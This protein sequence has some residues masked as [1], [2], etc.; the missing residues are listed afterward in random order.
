MVFIWN[1][2]IFL[3]YFLYFYTW[4]LA[5]AAKTKDTKPQRHLKARLFIETVVT[6][7]THCP[8]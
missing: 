5:L 6:S 7:L 2:S 1:V 8:I 3:N 4:S